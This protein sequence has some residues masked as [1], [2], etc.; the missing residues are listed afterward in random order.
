MILDDMANHEAIRHA[1]Q[2][3]DELVEIGKQMASNEGR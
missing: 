3:Y 1:I 2:I